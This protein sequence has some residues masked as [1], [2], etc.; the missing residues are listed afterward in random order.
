MAEGFRV[1]VCEV[2]GVWGPDCERCV[3]GGDDREKR[4]VFLEGNSAQKQCTK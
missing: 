3:D 4:R 2:W 1:V